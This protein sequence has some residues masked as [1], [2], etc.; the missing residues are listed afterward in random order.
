MTTDPVRAAYRR[1]FDTPD[2]QVVLDDIIAR[3]GV[4]RSVLDPADSRFHDGRRDLALQILAERAWSRIDLIALA[5]RQAEDEAHRE[6]MR[7]DPERE[8]ELS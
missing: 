8:G 5:E 6:I 7:Y 3:G 1:L 2:G 4:L